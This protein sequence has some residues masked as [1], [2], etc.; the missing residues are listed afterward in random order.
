MKSSQSEL[1]YHELKRLQEIPID[2]DDKEEAH[3]MFM[4]QYISV[5]KPESKRVW[6]S[7]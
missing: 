1:D 6:T 7:R 2:F 4:K 3:H 5:I